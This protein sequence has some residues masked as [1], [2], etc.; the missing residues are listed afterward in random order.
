MSSI[1]QRMLDKIIQPAIKGNETITTIA[2]VTASDDLNNRCS[3]EYVD[4]D[5][6]KK[7]K[8]NVAV[9]LY[10]N[11]AGYFPAVGE[12]VTLQLERDI[13][14]IVARHIGNYQMD[15]RSKMELKQDVFTDTDGAPPGGEVY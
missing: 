3:I 10:D 14:V 5:G 6:N 12:Q 7:A 13:C 2:K 15:V 1:S 9:R 11:G 8:D 4:R